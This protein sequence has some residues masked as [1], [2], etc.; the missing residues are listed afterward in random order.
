[1]LRRWW[2]VLMVTLT[3]IFSGLLVPPRSLIARDDQPQ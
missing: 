1:V 2:A 3:V